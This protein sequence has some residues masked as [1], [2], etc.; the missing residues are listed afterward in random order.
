MAGGRCRRGAGHRK[1]R[2][3]DARRVEIFAECHSPGHRIGTCRR[4]R[5]R[6]QGDARDSRRR[7]VHRIAA[8][9]RAG[10][11]AGGKHI[12]VLV[13][14]TADQIDQ[15]LA[16]QTGQVTATGRHSEARGVAGH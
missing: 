15:D 1:V 5:S 3:G 6:K 8:F 16:V 7:I 9:I 12:A 4:G 2:A 11:R 13:R 10:R 14:D